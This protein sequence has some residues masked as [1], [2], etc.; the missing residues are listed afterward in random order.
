MR[1]RAFLCGSAAIAR[2]ATRRR[3]AGGRE[4]LATVC[5]ASDRLRQ[6]FRWSSRPN[7]S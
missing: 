2:C 1:R 6:V 7:L 4:G 3:D 5:C